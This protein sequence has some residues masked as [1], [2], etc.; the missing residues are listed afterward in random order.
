MFEEIAQKNYSSNCTT[1]QRLLPLQCSLPVV[2]A[3]FSCRLVATRTGS[4]QRVAKDSKSRLLG[5]A[6][7]PA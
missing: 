6:E 7:T 1:C 5:A 4:R 2:G 3:F